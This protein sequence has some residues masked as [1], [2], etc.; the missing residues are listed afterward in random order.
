M[1]KYY[2][3]TVMALLPM[4]G[5]SRMMAEWAGLKQRLCLFLAGNTNGKCLDDEN[6]EFLS[7]AER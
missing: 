2:F 6:G 7:A 5:F 4:V 3:I 1:V